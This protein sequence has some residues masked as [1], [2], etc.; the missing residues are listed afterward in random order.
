MFEKWHDN[1]HALY[2]SADDLQVEMD[3]CIDE[4]KDISALSAEFE[5]LKSADLES[6]LYQQK[7]QALLDKTIALPVDG[8]FNEPS[9]L[10]GIR[11]GR[12]EL[13]SLPDRKLDDETLLDRI[14]GA[15]LGR[16][17]GCMLGKPVEG[18]RS[19]KIRAYLESQGRWPLSDYF[20]K[21]A[22]PEVSKTNGFDWDW[23]RMSAEGLSCSIEDD[24]TNYTVTGLALI[25]K[26][27]L[28]FTP[29]DVAAFWLNNIP[30][31]H[32]YT[33]E[34]VAY[35]NLCSMVPP[36]MSAVYRNPYREWIG[37]QI[38]GDFFGYVNHGNPEK[39]A[40]MAWRDASISHI[41]NGI[42][43]EMWV[44]AMLAA[45]SQ[46]NDVKSVICAG[47][48]QIPAASRLSHNINL[49]LNQFESGAD[50]DEAIAGLKS[51]W[52]EESPHHWCHTIS[53]AEI[54]A[55]ALLWGFGDFT[56]TLGY[57]VMPGFDTDCNGATAG[58]VLGMILGAKRLPGKWTKPLNDTLETGVARYHRVSISD[59][60]AKTFRLS[61]PA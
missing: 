43:G 30:I 6:G 21:Q 35:R 17:A 53:N 54:V 60:A 59:L 12:P 56:R 28:D 5:S 3:Q 14:H 33:A 22:D 10:E 34:R 1:L 57:A 7:A 2:I 20:S 9:D 38:R 25:E 48:S 50:Y 23:S 13:V 11:S 42:Y 47:L 45:A 44:A 29:Q 18:K 40:E 37:A 58:S 27:G 36:S 51:R 4:G 19:W 39:A 26:S 16:C 8:A 24:D 55:I 31:L 49:I 46:T 32:T 61:K 15:W 41:K 52:N